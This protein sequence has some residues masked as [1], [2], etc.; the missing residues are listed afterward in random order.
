MKGE[1]VHVHCKGSVNMGK[2]T[3]GKDIGKDK[4]EWG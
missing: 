4:G 2:N 1:E 3:V